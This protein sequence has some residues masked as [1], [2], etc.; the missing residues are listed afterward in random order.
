LTQGMARRVRKSVADQ[1]VGIPP[2]VKP[3]V[4]LKNGVAYSL[5]TNQR[6]VIFL[7]FEFG[8]FF[9]ATLAMWP[10]DQTIAALLLVIA[11]VLPSVMYYYDG[12]RTPRSVVISEESIV[13][14]FRF[15][16]P[17]K[18]EWDDIEFLQKIDVFERF[19]STSKTLGWM[20]ARSMKIPVVL[21]NKAGDVAIYAY[22]QKKGTSPPIKVIPKDTG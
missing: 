17:K 2:A 11:V 4:D 3:S 7:F 5:P 16:K 19:S 8:L 6:F 15:G 21:S 14:R 18:I 12:A 9:A 1:A 22:T 10:V 20:K 13:L